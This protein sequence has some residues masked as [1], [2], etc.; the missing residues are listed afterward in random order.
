MSPDEQR[1][2]V[3]RQVAALRRRGVS[4]A[5]A[6]SAVASGLPP[7][8]LAHEMGAALQ[9]LAAG[10]CPRRH[11]GLEWLLGRGTVPVEALEHAA[12]AL[13]ARLSAAAAVRLTRVYAGIGLAGPLALGSVLAWLVPSVLPEHSEPR[14]FWQ[15]LL[16]GAALLRYL[17]L[18]LAVAALAALRRGAG[19]LAPG[20]AA[21]GR[22]ASLLEAAAEG[23]D[24]ARHLSD[25]IERA[26]LAI[27]QESVGATRAAAELDEELVRDA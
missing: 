26:W 22:A 14:L 16:G 27:R 6:V 7:T 19:R 15:V 11:P 8:T 20:S 24:P 3:L 12:R 13:D 21:I 10:E 1:S 2:L 4:H 17:G 5:A 18:P 23:S 25:P 9:A